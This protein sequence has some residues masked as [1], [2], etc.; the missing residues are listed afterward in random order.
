MRHRVRLG[1]LLG[2]LAL[3]SC[4]SLGPEPPAYE[5]VVLASG[6]VVHDLVVPERTEEDRVAE[7]GDLVSLHYELS[8]N[9]GTLVDSSYERGLPIEIVLGDGV[10][11]PGLDE[12]VRGMRLFGRR[13]IVVPPE[14]G[15][16]DEGVPPRIPGRA[17]LLLEVELMGL[18]PGP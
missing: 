4:I 18:E 9:D 11:V 13:K 8:L 6:V 10:L 1:L 7:I 5:P 15:Y 14:L 17:L 3:T 12:G 2:F 16:G